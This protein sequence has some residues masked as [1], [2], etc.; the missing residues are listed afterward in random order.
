MATLIHPTDMCVMIE[1]ASW[2]TYESLLAD[3]GDN[4]A[5]RVTYADIRQGFAML[6]LNSRFY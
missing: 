1:G 5:A 2:A 4:R 3:F 6:L